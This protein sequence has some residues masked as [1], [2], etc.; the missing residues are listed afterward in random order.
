MADVVRHYQPINWLDRAIAYIAPGAG[1]KRAAHRIRF[2]VLA[3]YSR[4]GYEA[5]EPSRK[6]KFQRNNRSGDSLTRLA[7]QPLRNQARHLDRNHDIAKGALDRLTDFMVGPTGIQIEPQPKRRDGTI[8]TEYAR[9][10]QRRWT[11][12]TA[13][14]EVTWTLDWIACQRLACRTWLRDGEVLAQIVTGFRKDLVY[15][16]EI[17]V[18][19]E[20]LEPDFLPFSFDDAARN[21]RQGIQRNAWGRPTVYHVYKTHP[22]DYAATFEAVTKGVPAEQMIHVRLCDRLHQLRGV[23]V[24]ASVIERLQDI[25]E[26]EEAERIAA[27]MG[28]SMVLNLTHGAP[29]MFGT[30]GA[31]KPHDPSCPPIYQTESGMVVVS[32]QPG[33]SAEFFDTKRPNPNA[34]PFVQGNLKGASAGFGLSYSSTSR[35][36]SGTYSSQRQELV[37]NR[38]G[39]EAGT[40]VLVAQ[41]I[42]PTYETVVD[43][44]ALME[45]VPADVDPETI[46][47]ALF[48]GPPMIWIDPSREADAQLVLTQAGFTS[49]S[50][51]I[52]S[53]GG[54]PEDIDQQRKADRDREEK[55]KL[56][57]PLS[58]AKEPADANASDPKNITNLRQYLARRAAERRVTDPDLEPA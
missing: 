9:R 34:M 32:T 24:M 10:L 57:Q 40:M 7:A 41:M 49:R 19:L 35:D 3:N 5:A 51:V 54:N 15:G 2:N 47:D 38:P 55:L 14:P 52:R 58:P 28:A 44:D 1:E 43:W 30:I 20:L 45:P 26:Y 46:H 11:K 53:R 4:T 18:A 50:A 27:K 6:R 23:S 48:Q 56:G 33:A 22:G 16:S 21:I 36:Y 42:R 39:Y 17:P 37:E 31:G 13:W 25:Y 8:H 29:D 12:W